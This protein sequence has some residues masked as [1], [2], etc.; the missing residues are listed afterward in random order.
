[1]ID[2]TY[3]I[4]DPVKLPFGGM[5][6]QTDPF[7][8][9]AMYAQAPKPAPSSSEDAGALSPPGGSPAMGA[10]QGGSGG[11]S[12]L[13]MGMSPEM[14]AQYAA[15]PPEMSPEDQ[16]RSQLFTFFQNLSG[17]P[18]INPYEQN[19][20]RQLQNYK[21]QGERFNRLMGG[22]NKFGQEYAE[23]EFALQNGYFTPKEG[24]NRSQQFYRFRQ[25]KFKEEATPV[26][27]L[28]RR[29]LVE[30]AGLDPAVASKL[31]EGVYEVK[32]G[33][34]GITEII[35][36]STQEAV[37]TLT[38]DQAATIEEVVGRG[39]KLGESIDAQI[40][41]NIQKLY[42]LQVAKNEVSDLTE[43]GEQW[44]NTIS[45]KD[46]DGDYVFQTGPLQGLLASV[47]LADMKLGE[48]SA[49]DIMNR[50]QSLQIV[51]L[52]P[53]T[54]Q[55]L[56]AMGE[57]FATPSKV[58]AQNLGAIK[59]FLDKLKRT[60]RDL[61]RKMGNTRAWLT[62]YESKMSPYDREYLQRQYGDGWRVKEVDY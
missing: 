32:T 56:K 26:Y 25:E 50:L 6:D 49:T 30:D 35:D 61:D 55:E 13:P 38:A 29:G 18:M 1:M 34:G 10:L 22:S 21:L 8:E 7:A 54:Q 47:G 45:E 39:K 19:Y 17:R 28:R 23:F 40:G 37:S 43:F 44:F 48:L 9:L 4:F 62:S 16:R 27:E 5:M 14:M 60:Q 59:S 51:N 12:G 41:D 46:E 53:V 3:G 2:D 11:P 36:K 57:L 20:N 58:N 33:P 52:A 24:E 15:P 42:D 31:L